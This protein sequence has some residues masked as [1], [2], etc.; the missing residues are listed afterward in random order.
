MR[1]AIG[2]GWTLVRNERCRNMRKRNGG[3][4]EEWRLSEKKRRG[5][6]WYWDYW[7]LEEVKSAPWSKAQP[8]ETG[9]HL[10]DF[11]SH[12]SLA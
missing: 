9:L 11:L 12:L 7:E 4:D 3:E 1:N 8:S 5:E 2:G 6:V 10:L